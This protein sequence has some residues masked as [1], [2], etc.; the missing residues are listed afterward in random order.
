MKSHVGAWPERGMEGT[1]EPLIVATANIVRK[2]Y[3]QPRLSWQ[4]ATKY[5]IGEAYYLGVLHNNPPR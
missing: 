1:T 4:P 5:R 2:H 3:L